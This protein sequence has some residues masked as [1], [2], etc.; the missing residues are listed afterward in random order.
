MTPRGARA[1][2][3]HAAPPHDSYTLDRMLRTM[4][5]PAGR[6]VS[7][8]WGPVSRP[9]VA[10]A[11]RMRSVGAGAG[12]SHA[13]CHHFGPTRSA[14]SSAC[15]TQPTT[16]PLYPHR[17]PWMTAGCSQRPWPALCWAPP[18]WCGCQDRCREGTR[19]VGHWRWCGGRHQGVGP[20]QAAHLPAP[21]GTGA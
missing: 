16:P 8:G 14:P 18:R 1:H 3:T 17:V 13:V 15:L 21:P 9:D 6:A 2:Q 12:K 11:H 4:V 20:A 10:S 7:G 19:C 5:P